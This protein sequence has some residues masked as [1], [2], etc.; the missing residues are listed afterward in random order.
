MGRKLRRG[1]ARTRR[2]TDDGRAVLPPTIA[3]PLE[4]T[5]YEQ[6]RVVRSPWRRV[7]RIVLW[8]GSFVVVLPFASAGGAYLY[9]PESIR[10]I[11]AHSRDVNLAAKQLDI[12]LPN[13]PAIPLIL[14]YVAPTGP[15][16]WS[17]AQS[18]SDTVMLLR[19]DPVTNSI[20]MLSFPR[21]LT[22]DIWCHNKLVGRDRI[23]AA[24]TAC[25]STGTLETVKHLTGLPIN[26]IITVDF[27]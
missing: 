19:A 26:Y 1:M 21:D 25:Q 4:V 27:H 16:G 10:Q 9:Y 24:F 13:Q 12:P 2:I 5:R 14:R 6:P 3:S 17:A 11:G 8:L 20:S 18:R 23:N 22:T 7:G 15:N